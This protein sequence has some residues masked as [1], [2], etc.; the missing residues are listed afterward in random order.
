MSSC[1][2]SVMILFLPGLEARGAFELPHAL[3]EL[4]AALEAGPEAPPGVCLFDRDGAGVYA[5]ARDRVADRRARRDD[6]VVGDLQMT[7]EAR[8][9]A[10]HAALADGGG[11][12]DSATGG[13]RAV[14]PDAH[15]VS[16]LNEVV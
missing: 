9:A 14:R 12:G 4:R 1:S 16:D 2:G 3:I 15:V 5:G 11:A 8:H 10:D 7:R 6:D 13:D